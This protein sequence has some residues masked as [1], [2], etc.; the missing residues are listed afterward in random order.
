MSNLPVDVN[1]GPPKETDTPAN[2]DDMSDVTANNRK[3]PEVIEQ[4]M[5][6][7]VLKFSFVYSATTKHQIVAP[8]IIHTH[9]MQS[10]QEAF[11]EDVV[12]INNQNQHVEKISTVK[13][14][15]QTIHQKQFKLYQRTSGKD[16]KRNTTYHIL[17]RIL[18]NVTVGEIKAIPSVK[19]LMKDY[20]CYVTDHQ[21]NENQWDT[22]RI[23]FVTD[24]DPSF[25]NH[26]Q[27]V[28]KFNTLIHSKMSK[29]AKVPKF[30][31]VFSSPQIRPTTHT[32][33]TKAYALEV[34]KEDSM[35]ML[36]LLEPI[37]QDT[38]TFVPYTLRRKYP[39]G[40][41]KAIRYQTH[42][43]TSS[44]VVILQ[45]ITEGMMFYLQDHILS[46]HG[47]RDILF[48]P[49]GTDTGRWSVKVDKTQFANIRKHLSTAISEWVD[50]EV[51]ID[52]MPHPERFPGPARVK[53]L[54]DDGQWSGAN[55]WMTQSNASFYVNGTPTRNWRRLFPQ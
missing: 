9:W 42:L 50:T 47:V 46:I 39:D 13:W 18:T 16:E 17:H 40:Y 14:S 38:P 32:T 2:H 33:S 7:K 5:V 30:R 41:E 8:S 24:F 1:H 35:E 55:S 21:W 22:I 19:K 26:T 25:F 43:L 45:N 44:M 48:S 49:K 54:Y 6:S 3:N 37:F 36:K 34:L 4:E 20:Q 11:N 29:K 51:S 31:F 27:A 28:A 53:P 52:A 15:D 10:V 23:G 12:I